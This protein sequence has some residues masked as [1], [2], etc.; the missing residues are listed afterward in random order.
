V[1]KSQFNQKLSG[2]ALTAGIVCYVF[3][4]FVPLVFQLIGRKG[5]GAWEL[6]A[7]R[8]LW[9]APTAFILVL[10]CGLWSRVA[11]VV[12]NPR[13]VAWLMLSA[14]LIG[15]NW[16]VYIW[17]VNNG[18]VLAT[19][20]GYY[21]TPLVNMA[22]GAL[23]FGERISRYRALAI[24]ITVLGVIVQGIAVGGLPWPSIALALAFGLYGIVRK[25]VA[26]DAITGL[27]V[28][29]MFIGSGGLL[30]VLWLETHGAGH[31]LSS[32]SL[33]AWLI[34]VGPISAIPLALFSWA[35]RRI[36]L[37]FM[38]FLQF[39]TPSIALVVGLA[40]GETLS[41]TRAASFTLIWCGAL[42]ATFDTFWRTGTAITAMESS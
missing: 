2:S 28:E 25:H 24:A 15:I 17:S 23:I 14:L 40:E 10:G 27:F 22:G 33:C 20:F 9:A 13:T 1:A 35:A 4:G 41:A 39:L 6:L 29:C 11:A 3:W 37:S 19:S 5:V 30:Y 31:F 18:Q 32:A 36:P 34:A 38:A 12:S 16:I 7:H 26:A 42:I 21:I 8:S